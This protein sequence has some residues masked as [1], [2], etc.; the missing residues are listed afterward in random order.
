LTVNLSPSPAQFEQH[1]R[2]KKK[3]KKKN[4]KKK[5]KKKKKKQKTPA[6]PLPERGRGPACRCGRSARSYRAVSGAAAAHPVSSRQAAVEAARTRRTVF[7]AI[8]VSASAVLAVVLLAPHGTSP[9][10]R[11]A[12]ALLPHRTLRNCSFARW[13]AIAATTRRAPPR[14][15][16]GRPSVTPAQRARR[17]R[18]PIAALASSLIA[19]RPRVIAALSARPHR[20][21]R[22]K[23]AQAGRVRRSGSSGR[24]VAA[25]RGQSAARPS[26]CF[27]QVIARSPAMPR[28][29][30]T[31]RRAER[32]RAASWW[33]PTGLCLRRARRRGGNR[34][35]RA[36]A[37]TCAARQARAAK[38][39]AGR[40]LRQAFTECSLP[41]P[42]VRQQL[43]RRCR[44]SFYI[45]V[46]RA[47][48]AR[49]DPSSNRSRGDIGRG[50]L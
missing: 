39:K 50:L 17:S 36:G 20:R 26:R 23:L 41:D 28:R 37:T 42:A 33:P 27:D 43:R 49:G 29:C 34:G 11:S 12:A 22:C 14:G 8:A 16:S 45:A 47:T 3:K 30:G 24:I 7:S 31:R 38:L 2:E 10:A 5:K 15:S 32:P 48:R 18:A 1:S 21:G 46:R 19:A 9:I 44:P 13:M 4:G 35:R 25:H 6:T 40:S